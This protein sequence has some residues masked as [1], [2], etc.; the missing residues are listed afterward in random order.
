MLNAGIRVFDIRYAF[1]VTNSTLVYWHS[2][3]LV[4]QTASVEDTLFGFYIWLDDHPNET[5]LLSFQYEGSTTLHGTNNAEVQHALYDLLT[6]AA[7]RKYFLQT[8]DRFGTLGEARGKITLLK[9]F[10]LDQLPSSYSASLPGIHFSPSQW[11]DNS[12]S[13]ALTYNAALN[14]T[15]YIEDLYEPPGPTGST[16]A[17]NIALK[18]NATVAHLERAAS[19]EAADSLWWSF[20]S[21]ENDANVPIDTPR[22]MALG[23]GTLT[24]LGGVNRRLL[25]WLSGQKGKRMGIVMFDFFDE[26]G[27]LVEVFLGLKGA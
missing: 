18:Y 10:D 2:Q 13:I 12:P 19:G 26:P 22:I 27:E 6:S 8:K 17:Y 14:Q 4:S 20:A 9:R 15:A 23:N 24:P 16:A 21:A 3:A 1:D 5:L 7:A 11:T 25:N